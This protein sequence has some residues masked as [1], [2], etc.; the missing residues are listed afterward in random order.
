MQGCF[1]SKSK[2]VSKRRG[3]TIVELL[4]VIVVIGIL[5]AITIVAYSGIQQRAR[6]SVRAQ[7]LSSI[8]QALLLY[9]TDHGGVPMTNTYG[10][11]GP[12]GWNISSMPSWLS[13]INSS[14]YGRMP[15]DPVNT[16]TTDPGLGYE[17]T[18]FYYCYPT[19]S[20]TMPATPNVSLGYYS[21]STHGSK[22]AYFAVDQCL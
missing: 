3:F 22:W 5:A 19:G 21:E 2:R 16:G 11:N 9:N 1:R 15:V 13:F 4:I 12:G 6:D 7:D 18:Y 14:T 20:G 8:K 17:L 10:G